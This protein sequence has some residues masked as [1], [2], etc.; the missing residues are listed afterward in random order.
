MK[1]GALSQ[2]H[3]THCSA[4]DD[5]MMM[6]VMMYDDGGG[7]DDDNGGGFPPRHCPTAHKG[8]EGW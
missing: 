2:V 4:C 7:D 5:E 3:A 6:M 8:K 1:E